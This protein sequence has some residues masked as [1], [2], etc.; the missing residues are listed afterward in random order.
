MKRKILLVLTIILTVFLWFIAVFS[1]TNISKIRGSFEPVSSWTG[2]H[3]G[4]VIFDIGVSNSWYTAFRD[5]DW[6][7]SWFFWLG[8]AGWATF[9]QVD[10]SNI[11]LCQSRIVCPSNILQ[12]PYQLC[13]VYGC[14]WSQ[15]AGWIIMSGSM[16]NT[17]STGV[18]YNPSTALMEWWAWNKW[19]GWIPFLAKTDNQELWI[20]PVTSSGIT[21][22]GVG[23]HF[24]GKMAII[25][26]IAG[27]RIFE[28]PNQNVGYVFSNTSHASIMNT[29]RK[30]IALISRNIDA[31]TLASDTSP[32]NFLIRKDQDY[33]FY[34]GDVWPVWKD[35]IIIIGHDVVL[36]TSNDIGNDTDGKVRW[37]IVLK[38][39]DG[40][41]WN[42]IISDKVKRIYALMF[43]EWSVFSGE[44][45]GTWIVPYLTRWVWNIPQNQLYIKWL[46][47]SKNT[48]WGSR[49]TPIVCPVVTD[50]CD[51]A[52]AE[53]YDLNYFRT[54]DP[55]D[56]SQFS[57]PYTA[58]Y[59]NNSSMI[60]EYN[61]AILT[62]PPP[63]LIDTIQ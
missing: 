29:I 3:P 2:W 6:Y 42:I 57:A 12:N 30:N 13:P 58:S 39:E 36:D 11:P 41:G 37:L 53:L 48:I 18:Y 59:T 31:S 50:T 14:A 5:Q 25:G 61:N 26:N 45:T 20:D 56:V 44:K 1:A 21:M 43:A 27:T 34:F 24:I 35:S 46:L 38:D 51:Q 55:T 33:V 28:L 54:F 60:I 7:L 17:T 32:F 9:N 22:D 10:G 8:N 63:W 49:Q 40:N 19:L 16:I 4:R 52:T 47:I 23:I 15:N 62:N